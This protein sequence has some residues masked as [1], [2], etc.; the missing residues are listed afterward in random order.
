MDRRQ[1]DGGCFRKVEA[2]GLGSCAG[3][4]DGLL[5][6]TGG[7]GEV[8]TGELVFSGADLGPLGGETGG[9]VERDEA[10]LWRA[11]KIGRDGEICMQMRRIRCV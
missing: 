7:Y 5:K 11:N 3:D 2:G 1:V 9:V 4:Y 8:W 6:G 10:V